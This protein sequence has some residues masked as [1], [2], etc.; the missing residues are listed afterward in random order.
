MGTVSQLHWDTHREG[1]ETQVP[2][3]GCHQVIKH[4][5][6]S[7]RTKPLPPPPPVK[8]KGIIAIGIPQLRFQ[9]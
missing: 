3:L 5:N 4:F 6:A 1:I 8:N 9:R 2:K 7:R